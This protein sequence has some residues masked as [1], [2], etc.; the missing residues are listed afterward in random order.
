[1]VG[2]LSSA[3]D[4]GRY[5]AMHV[6]RHEV[7]RSRRSGGQYP[8]HGMERVEGDWCLMEL[9]RRAGRKRLSPMPGIGWVLAGCVH[10]L[11]QECCRE[12]HIQQLEK[13]D[14]GLER[15]PEGTWP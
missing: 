6:F 3:R 13:R 1:M 8:C 14:S 10:L 7:V 15:P 11:S 4:S 12:P 9:Q 2:E 5:Q